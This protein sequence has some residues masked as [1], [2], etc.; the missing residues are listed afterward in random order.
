MHD[1]FPRPRLKHSPLFSAIPYGRLIGNR[2]CKPHILLFTRSFPRVHNSSREISTITRAW[3]YHNVTVISKLEN[4]KR[5]R[6]KREVSYFVRLECA[7]M[8][9]NN[10]GKESRLRLVDFRNTPN[11]G[12]KISICQICFL[13][14][15]QMLT[16]SHVQWT[17]ICKIVNSENL[18]YI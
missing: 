4:G 2:S 12:N 15:V 7:Q 16:S 9:V 17:I 5:R 1:V 8:G 13:A 10:K 3:L 14:M 11:S 18:H 6:I